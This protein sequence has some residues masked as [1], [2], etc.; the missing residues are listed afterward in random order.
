MYYKI[1]EHFGPESGDK[2]LNYIG[3]SGLHNM[4]RFDSVDSMMRPNIFSPE[5]VED[6]NNC[7]NEDF[8]LNLITN[9]EYAKEISKKYADAEMVGVDIDINEHYVPSDNF[10]GYDIIDRYCSV[11][12]LTNW[13]RDKYPFDR[14]VIKENGLILNIKEAIATRDQL[15]KDPMADDHSRDCTLWAVYKIRY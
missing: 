3:W 8:K 13:I 2:W 5:T 7:V 14:K 15:R 10:L 12:L 1:L 9:L 4:K 11:S 6:W